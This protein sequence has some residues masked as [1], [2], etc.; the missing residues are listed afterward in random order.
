[1][2]PR[3]QHAHKVSFG[4]RGDCLN[5]ADATTTLFDACNSVAGFTRDVERRHMPT[6]GAM[7]AK[8]RR[9]EARG[10]RREIA[11][12]YRDMI[13]P[14]WRAVLPTA[15]V[16]VVYLWM[17]R[18]RD[19]RGGNCRIRHLLAVAKRHSRQ[20]PMALSSDGQCSESSLPVVLEFFN[21]P[22]EL[23]VAEPWVH[24]GEKGGSAAV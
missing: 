22:S 13:L 23:Q 7:L 21:E 24:V 15:D 12:T 11:S 20:R 2:P 16:D 19:G 8:R 6:K 5:A 14:R 10:E 9:D 18:D 1:M 4:L 3:A 17:G